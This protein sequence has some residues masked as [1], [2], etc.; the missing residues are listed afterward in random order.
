M[1]TVRID[2]DSLNLNFNGGENLKIKLDQGIVRSDFDNALRT[3]YILYLGAISG[4]FAFSI[5]LCDIINPWML[6]DF[7]ALTSM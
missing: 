5:S 3:L 6:F 7:V 2:L 4:N 1:N